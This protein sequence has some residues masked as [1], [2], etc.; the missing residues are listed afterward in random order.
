M[1]FAHGATLDLG[2]VALAQVIDAF[3]YHRLRS[4]GAGRDQDRLHTLKP[5]TLDLADGVDQVSRL[6]A[7][8]SDL[9]QAHA[10]GTIAATEH[11]HQVGFRDKLLDR[12]LAVLRRITD[13]VPR[14]ADNSREAT[15]Q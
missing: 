8:T 7:T 6:A 13:I 10:V 3:L 5:L 12:F 1:L 2:A 4:A 11:E 9:C 14:G 15:A